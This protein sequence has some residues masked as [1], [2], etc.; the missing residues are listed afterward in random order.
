MIS[1][2]YKEIYDVFINHY[3]IKH[4]DPGHEI[5]EDELNSIFNKIIS[6]QNINDDYSFNYLMNYIIKKLSGILDAHTQY[7]DVQ[8]IPMNFKLFDN[9]VIVNYPNNLKGAN[10]ISINGIDMNIIIKELD[11]IITYGTEG[12]R[13]YEIEQALFNK[14]NYLVYQCL[15]IMKF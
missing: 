11:N 3:K 8:I 7:E 1:T 5:T 13:K 9:E 4:V 14:K 15:G 12:K 2:K 10:L 6:T